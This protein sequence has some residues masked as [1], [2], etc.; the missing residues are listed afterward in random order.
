MGGLTD[1]VD[2][3]LPGDDRGLVGRG[4]SSCSPAP[5][6][7]PSDDCGDDDSEEGGVTISMA[8]SF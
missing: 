8:F 7:L 6:R 4:D 2:D 1:K 5:D 3:E